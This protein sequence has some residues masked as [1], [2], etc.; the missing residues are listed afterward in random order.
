M[1]LCFSFSTFSYSTIL[2]LYIFLV[3]FSLQ[4][5]SWSTMSM[6]RMTW[7]EIPGG[8]GIYC[9]NVSQSGEAQV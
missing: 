1:K 6:M 3:C 8:V 2:K 9:T 7:S 4:L 5:L